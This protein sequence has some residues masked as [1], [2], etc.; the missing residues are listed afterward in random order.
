MGSP[1]LLLVYLSLSVAPQQPQSSSA[2]TQKTQTESQAVPAAKTTASISG[3]V[4]Q[5]ERQPIRKVKVSL[6]SDVPGE[7][8]LET[9]SDAEG[10]FTFKEL[11]AGRYRLQAQH[12]GFVVP[13]RTVLSQVNTVMLREGQH[14]ADLT[15]KLIAASIIKGVV[16]DEDGD[17]VQHVLVQVQQQ[18]YVRGKRRAMP[19]GGAQTNDLGEF[20]ISGLIPGSYYLVAAPAFRMMAPTTPA[21]TSN[22]RQDVKTFY[23]GALD[24]QNATQLQIRG[25]EELPA[26]I[27]LMRAETVAVKGTVYSANGDKAGSGTL[28]IAVAGDPSPFGQP[29]TMVHDGIFEARVLPGQYR[30]TSMVTEAGQIGSMSTASETVVVSR[31]GIEGVQLR[32]A[33]GAKVNVQLRVEGYP[34]ID[35]EKLHFNLVRRLEDDADV[36]STF[37]NFNSGKT[38]K[39]GV[40]EIERVVP[41]N[42][43]GTWFYQASGLEDHYLKSLVLGTRDVTADGARV[44]SDPLQLKVVISAGAPKIDGT[45]TQSQSQAVKKAFIVAVPEGER[46][47]RENTWKTTSSDQY[48]HFTLRGLTPG[49]YTLLALEDPDIGIWMD[50]DFLKKVEDRG[51]SISVRENDREQVQLRL[52]PAAE[53]TSSIQ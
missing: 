36:G 3:A 23:P 32:T 20:R 49:R 38:N 52:I 22:S 42:Y 46:R 17:P 8:P 26:N 5:G 35:Y 24:L 10:H 51:T 2:A 29:T 11:A 19:V 18:Q 41:G 13:R 37:M 48:G 34:G 40:V 16:S 9:E 1:A 50:P 39:D 14:I 4:L 21:P 7:T 25:G 43:D 28:F 31:E 44:S 33:R 27:T 30:I 15:I 53:T 12:P 47:K 45:V 6:R